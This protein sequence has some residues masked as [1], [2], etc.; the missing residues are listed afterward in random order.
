MAIDNNR[1]R[2][3]R[4][5]GRVQFKTIRH[6]KDF[7][8]AEIRASWYR[9]PDY[10][11]MSEEVSK[12]A[13]LVAKGLDFDGDEEL[14]TRGLEH[15]VEEDVADYRAEKMVASVD[16]VLDEQEE[17][18]SEE[19]YDP[20]IIAAIYA[21]IVAPL[22]KQAYLTALRDALDATNAVKEMDEK[23]ATNRSSA[24][25]HPRVPTRSCETT[26]SD[27]TNGSYET[28][29]EAS[30]PEDDSANSLDYF[31]SEVQTEKIRSPVPNKPVVAQPGAS[32]LPAPSVADEQ[33]TKKSPVRR[34]RLD[35]KGGTE[36]SPLVRRMDGT[37][38]FRN[39]ELDLSKLEMS[40]QRKESVRQSLWKHL[41]SPELQPKKKTSGVQKGEGGS[42]LTVI[43]QCTLDEP[44]PISGKA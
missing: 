14:C 34:K 19:N 27:A 43:D 6:V 21:E 3:V 5:H 24:E 11:R 9:K 13:K 18:R 41:D 28:C 16:A 17:Q 35:R 29:E 8:D 32:S 38:M 2:K 12:I 25:S 31:A 1:S 10:V 4:F 15:L 36:L 7:S 37:F 23:M 20:D 26:D 40:K 33:Q 42:I 44:V 30:T 22:Q 39:K